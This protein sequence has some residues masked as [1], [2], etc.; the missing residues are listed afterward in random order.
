M[1]Q[2]GWGDPIETSVTLAYRRKG[3]MCEHKFSGSVAIIGE[4]RKTLT[5]LKR[6][7]LP[8]REGRLDLTNVPVVGIGGKRKQ[9][10]GRVQ[11]FLEE[12]ISFRGAFVLYPG[13]G[14]WD[15]GEG[16]LFVTSR[17]ILSGRRVS[18][19]KPELQFTNHRWLR[20]GRYVADHAKMLHGKVIETIKAELEQE[21]TP[22]AIVKAIAGWQFPHRLRDVIDSVSREL[23]EL[24]GR[25]VMLTGEQMR[26]MTALVRAKLTEKIQGVRF[27]RDIS[28]SITVTS[29]EIAPELISERDNLGTIVIPGVG[30]R[31]PTKQSA[32]FF[33]GDHVPVVAFSIEEF[34]QIESWPFANVYPVLK[35]IGETREQLD[36][37]LRYA[38]EAPE[39]ERMGKLREYFAG[40]WLNVQRNKNRP[41]DEQVINPL[42]ADPPA[43]PNPVVWGY[44]IM[45]GEVKTAYAALV[46]DVHGAKGRIVDSGWSIRWY[47][48]ADE[49]AKADVEGRREAESF[50]TARRLMAELTANAKAT[51]LPVAVPMPYAAQSHSP[52]QVLSMASFTSDQYRIRT[53]VSH[54]YTRGSSGGRN[55]DYEW[56]EGS[57]S[58]GSFARKGN[59]GVWE[60]GQS[61]LTHLFEGGSIGDCN[62]QAFAQ[63]VLSQ[64]GVGEKI[65]TIQEQFK[66][67]RE[68]SEDAHRSSI[69][70]FVSKLQTLPAYASLSSDMQAKLADLAS[71]NWGTPSIDEDELKIEWAKAKA[72]YAREQTGEVLTNWG[73]HFRVM[74]ATDNRDYWVVR[75][76]G[77]LRDPEEISYRKR[78]TSE[79]NKQWRLVGPDELALTWS[80]AYTAAPH[81]FSVNKLPVN[82]CTDEQFTTVERIEREISERFRGTTGMSGT[83]SPGIGHGWKLRKKSAPELKPESDAPALNGEPADLS[84]VD[85]S[86]L[87]GGS[88]KTTSKRR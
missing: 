24:E 46:H 16:M 38:I 55:N 29:E 19:G 9:Q 23:Y 62:W 47:D 34:R 50:I 33:F 76:D 31:L 4:D 57:P 56:E 17:E 32:S 45:T 21:T 79:G 87:F 39:A 54:W 44:D 30:R 64:M 85:M 58:T 81:E 68:A 84:K 66:V 59:D 20:D 43:M 36:Y 15:L 12:N 82:G 52:E 22:E 73:G 51:E 49:A 69:R 27:V 75:L 13:T 7:E 71:N 37:G 28:D 3:D 8:L 77:T 5:W 48:D 61:G 26:D 60:I 63:P 42:E 53:D 1:D 88:A 2:F 41:K 80:K 65:A 11:T 83:V 86:K 40:M 14:N 25:R 78:Y 72:L 10:I 18:G 67:E 74:G 6:E 70:S 35:E